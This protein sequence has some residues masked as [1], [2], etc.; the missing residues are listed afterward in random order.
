MVTW[1]NCDVIP[2]IPELLYP[3]GFIS[4]FSRNVT[5]SSGVRISGNSRCWCYYLIGHVYRK[6]NELSNEDLRKSGLGFRHRILSFF[7]QESV[8]VGVH[9]R[10]LLSSSVLMYICGHFSF[11][12][13]LA[14]WPFW[15]RDKNGFETRTIDSKPRYE[16]GHRC[17]YHR[18]RM[19]SGRILM[20]NS[21]INV[22]NQEISSTYSYFDNKQRLAAKAEEGAYSKS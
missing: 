2:G 3:A 12:S 20:Q 7:S 14:C 9:L 17:V 4:I 8:R 19:G 21:L 16:R 18:K 10:A 15:S 1:N 11:Y 5:Y 22:N 6:I 13:F